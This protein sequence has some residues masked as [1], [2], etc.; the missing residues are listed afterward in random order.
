LLAAP[1]RAEGVAIEKMVSTSSWARAPSAGAEAAACSLAARA[2]VD[3]EDKA[4]QVRFEDAHGS[5]PCAA[6]PVGA[7]W[8]TVRA[9]EQGGGTRIVVEA[10]VAAAAASPTVSELE[11]IVR[12]TADEM[13]R[14]LEANEQ[15]AVVPRMRAYSPALT[16]TGIALGVAGFAALT[17]GYTWLIVIFSQPNL[18]PPCGWFGCTAH[19]DDPTVPGFLTGIGFGSMLIAAGLAAIGERRVPIQSAR[20]VPLLSPQSV[21]FAL[22]F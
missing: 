10:R 6:A 1:A 14:R 17:I 8:M 9:F 21:G 19:Y 5:R 16:A 7:L 2:R 11:E 18:T 3:N 13:K 20:V 4:I 22:S 15:V 12:A